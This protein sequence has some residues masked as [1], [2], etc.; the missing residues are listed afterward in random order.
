VNVVN[1]LTLQKDER[2]ENGSFLYV[3]PG[4]RAAEERFAGDTLPAEGS[5]TG[6]R[7]VSCFCA[8]VAPQTRP[9]T[10]TNTALVFTIS[11]F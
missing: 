4:A 9:N 5:V 1:G 10:S 6:Q 11:C 2:E 3:S 8:C 7:L